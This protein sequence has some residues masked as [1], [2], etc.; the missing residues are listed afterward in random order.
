MMI[1]EDID[2]ILSEPANSVYFNFIMIILWLILS[3]IEIQQGISG[4]YL[5]C[6]G[7]FIG[8]NTHIMIREFY[9]W[10]SLKQ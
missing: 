8:I 10:K 5:V 2:K 6:N 4:W 9:V 7:F 3:I 1:L